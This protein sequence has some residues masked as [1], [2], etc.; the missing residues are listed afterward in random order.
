MIPA[1]RKRFNE[2]F[3]PGRYQAYIQEL[4]SLYP[5]H[6]EFRIAET[7]V[8]IPATFRE[9]M[10]E[11]C[12]AI[13][14]T[15]LSPQYRQ[16]SERAIPPG[17]R[18]PG[19]EEV[20][21]FIAFD[22]GICRAADGTIEPQLIEMQGFPTLF[23]WHLLVPEIAAR[24]YDLP[25]DF[26]N[27]LNGFDRDRYVELLRSI[28]VRDADPKETILLEILPGQQKTRVD[29]MAT[30]D[31]LGIRTVCLTEL[32]REGRKLY[33][34][35][36]G[37]RTPVRRIYNRLIFDDLQQQ[38]PEVQEQG[39]ILMEDLDVQWAPHPNWFY[40]L[41]KF[42]LPYIRHRYVPETRFLD[43][44]DALP[45][46]LGQYVVKPLFSFAGQGVLIDV[47][48]ADLKA[49]PDPQNW[50]LQRKV[51]YAPLIE[52]PDEGAKAEIRLFY[53]W[54]PGAGRPVAVNNLARLS[55]GKMVGVRYNQDKEW[56]GG[57]YCLF[58]NNRGLAGF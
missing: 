19:D 30:E 13:L 6:L 39:K 28:I 35:R 54:P 29:F 50:I 27:F 20:P 37:V 24:H 31:L 12:E 18:V 43:Q 23:A 9:A 15:V 5:G 34:L 48:E 25:E 40:R 53:F 45:A 51:D 44:V 16:E 33:Y 36:D 11:A 32:I 46:D 22:F 8:F 58:A 38:A 3:T 21:A 49:I 52:T 41:S 57:S 10:L 47:T 7:P 2:A 1:Q 26:T 42:T 55:K 56:V 4:A 17:L 14:D